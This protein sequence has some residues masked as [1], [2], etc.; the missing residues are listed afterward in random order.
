MNGNSESVRK[1]LPQPPPRNGEGEASGGRQ[2]PVQA[3]N[4]GLTS[5]ARLS[6]L[7]FG[8]GLGEGFSD[9]LSSAGP[10]RLLGPLVLLLSLTMPLPALAGPVTHSAGAVPLLLAEEDGGGKRWSVGKLLSGLNTRAR[11]VQV[12]VVVMALALFILIKK[13]T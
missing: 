8:E 3:R 4:R 1:R 11:V 13:L 9:R 5:P 7:R 10:L 6:P 12:C 2:P